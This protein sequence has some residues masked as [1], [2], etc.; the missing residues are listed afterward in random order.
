MR[1]SKL[2]KI[3]LSKHTALS[4]KVRAEKSHRIKDRIFAEFDLR[5]INVLHFF[6]PIEVKMEVDVGLIM[7]GVWDDYPQIRTIS[8]RVNFDAN[9][10]EHLDVGPGSTLKTNHWGRPEPVGDRLVKEKSLDMV[11]VPLLCFDHAG[12]RI[13][14]GKG[15]YDVF[16]TKCRK[17]CVKVGLSFFEPVENI[18]D[19]EDHD[20]PVDF[21]V[22]PQKLWVF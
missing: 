22:T 16:L 21:G 8:S 1:K 12:N 4:R 3:Y 11:L 9:K 17:D 6:N 13:G 15:F 5:S 14:Y 10:L 2:R 20:V 19:V 18:D 7:D